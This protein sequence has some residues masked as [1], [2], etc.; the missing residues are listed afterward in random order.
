M[1]SVFL[2]CS[3]VFQVVFLM[4]VT[5]TFPA[6]NFNTPSPDK[7][8]CTGY[9]LLNQIVLLLLLCRNNAAC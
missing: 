5:R 8:T 1:E 4:G 6:V 2:I 3:I 7:K 9:G